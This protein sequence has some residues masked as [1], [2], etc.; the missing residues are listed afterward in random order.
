VSAL[1]LH[2]REALARIAARA[3]AQADVAL[4]CARSSEY[5]PADADVDLII[6]HLDDLDLV[7]ERGLP[8]AARLVLYGRAIAARASEI[9]GGA[10]ILESPFRT[11]DLVR[12]LE[13]HAPSTRPASPEPPTGPGRSSGERGAL[14]PAAQGY[15]IL[16]VDDDVVIRRIYQGV[17]GDAGYRVLTARDGEEAWENLP[18]FGPD[19]VISDV[20]MPR[21]DG[22]G[23]CR[24]IKEH[25]Q[26]SQTPVIICSSLSQGRDVVRAFE[27]GTDDYL[28]KPIHED[29]L[30]S[31]VSELLASIEQG[32]R[33]P[34]LVVD[35][36]R[37]IRNLIRGGL[38]KHGF[39]V[40][41]AED[42]KDALEKVASMDP[43]P[44]VIISDFEMPRMGGFDL[45]MALRSDERT[46]SVPLIMMSARD[47]T[48]NRKLMKAAG[49]VGFL[50]KPFEPDKMVALVERVLGEQRLKAEQAK[51]RELIADDAA[52]QLVRDVR[53]GRK[54]V[55]RTEQMTLLF[56]DLKGF[57]TMCSHLSAEEVVDLLNGYFDAMIPPIREAEGDVDKFIG[58]AI[59]ARFRDPDDGVEREPGPLR[60]IRAGLG[61]IEALKEYNA[62]LPGGHELHM[63]IGIN[64]GE[65]VIGAIGASSRRDYTTIGDNVNRAQRLE[66]NASVD[67]VLIAEST[68][69]LVK[70]RVKVKKRRQKVKL[71]GIAEPVNAYDV[72]GIKEREG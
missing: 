15:K 29:E 19:L 22:Y 55:A 53:L 66:S 28:I 46:R 42:G 26:W 38:S 60:A 41:T 32:G 64:H 11:R 39:E 13:E 62:G 16:A 33:E 63:R 14:D 49:A 71:K 72:L 47:D 35:D 17:L 54:S 70:G 40:S 50:G 48:R 65:V 61:M 36:S 59:M 58:D 24:R 8:E 5:A 25:P 23:L 44:A 31:R 27:S 30:V 9:P 43:L 34:I 68:Y 51:I 56:S 4:A 20:E 52:A 45:G 7:K 12:I 1:F 37:I 3:G 57:S 69:Q 67:G 21:L 10:A 6:V 18:G 2:R